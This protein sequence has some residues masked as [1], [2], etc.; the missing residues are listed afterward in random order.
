MGRQLHETNKTVRR[1]LTYLEERKLIVRTRTGVTANLQ[2]VRSRMSPAIS[3]E[4]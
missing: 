1:D 2:R 4:G 3:D